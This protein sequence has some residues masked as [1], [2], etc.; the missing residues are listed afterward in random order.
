MALSAIVDRLSP[1]FAIEQMRR[2]DSPKLHSRCSALTG[3]ELLNII[4]NLLIQ[5][6]RPAGCDNIGVVRVRKGVKVPQQ[7]Q[8]GGKHFNSE[9]P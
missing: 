8:M 3:W 6:T 2:E 1:K 9:H 4:S 7:N 5:T